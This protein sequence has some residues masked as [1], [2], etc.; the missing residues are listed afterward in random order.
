M[1]LTGAAPAHDQ[2]ARRLDGGAAEH[3]ATP[4]HDQPAR[5][6]DGG[7]AEHDATPAHDQPAR[8]H[9]QAP[10]P[11]VTACAAAGPG[12]SGAALAAAGT[13]RPTSSNDAVTAGAGG[14]SPSP[15]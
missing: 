1:R 11:T 3:D 8:R 10:A 14:L 7:A 6:L 9:D 4:A 15:G 13:A 2:P 12:W 5:R